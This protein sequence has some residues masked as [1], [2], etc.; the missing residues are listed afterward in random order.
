MRTRT[1][2]TI[3]PSLAL[4]A[5][6]ALLMPQTTISQPWRQSPARAAGAN[7]RPA[8]V[9]R[10]EA[11][12]MTRL[13]EPVVIVPLLTPGNRPIVTAMING[14]GPFKLGIETGSAA[15]L[16][17]F[18]KTMR[19]LQLPDGTDMNRARTIDSVR[20][21]G[22]LMLDISAFVPGESP[23]PTQLDGFLGLAAYSRLTMELDIPGG[24]VLFTA[25]TL[26][27]VNGADVLALLDAGDMLA[28]AMHAGNRMLNLVLDSQGGLGLAV[29]SSL[30]GEL[31]LASPFV[32][33]GTLSGMAIGT[34]TRRTARVSGNMTLGRYSFDRPLLAADVVPDG[35]PAD[36]IMGMHAL[37]A[38]SV[39]LDQR[40]HRVRFTRSEPVIAAPGPLH[41]H[42]FTVAYGGNFLEVASVLPNAPAAASTIRRGDLIVEANGQSTR[43]WAPSDWEPVAESAEPLE[44]VIERAGKTLIVNL[45]ALLLVQ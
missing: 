9:F 29:R 45:P 23:I 40:T 44:L 22:L 25:D 6:C 36:G 20:I 38:F 21:G 28:V 4:L 34:I 35:L 1:A 16:L 15:P 33:I 31:P 12:R 39:A 42:G 7:V 10:S 37:S 24:R 30:V 18:T 14:R 2:S 19:A 5:A 11:P 17:L 26:P 32:Q 8:L 27:E 43:G 13:A 41:G 3:T